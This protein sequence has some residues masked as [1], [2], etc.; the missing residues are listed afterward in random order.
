[1]SCLFCKIIE[2]SI[3]STKVYEDDRCLVFKDI[4][5]QAPIHLLLIPKEHIQSL[6]EIGEEQ[7]ALMGHMM[8][9]VAQMADAL[10]LK[11][12]FRLVSNC[13]ADAQQ[14]VSHLHFHLLA[15]RKLEWPPG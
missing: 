2:G 7:S 10:E 15:G 13:G 11:N 9:V 14:S 3:P 6:A 8:Q 1:M 12:G 5:P 4:E